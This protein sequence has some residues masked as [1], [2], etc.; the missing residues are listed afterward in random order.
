M[1]TPKLFISYSW[2]STEHEN[3]FSQNES[4]YPKQRPIWLVHYWFG[5]IHSRIS[6][7]GN[8]RITNQTVHFYV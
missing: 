5:V 4:H 3:W 6:M 2:T 8:F 7:V 1:I